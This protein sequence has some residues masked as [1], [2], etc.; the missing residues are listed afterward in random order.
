[1][2]GFRVNAVDWCIPRP[3]SMNAA[4]LETTSEETMQPWVDRHPLLFVLLNISIVYATVSVVISYVGGWASLSKRF[5]FH[6][7]FSGS[8]WRGQSGQ[9]RWIAGYRSYLTVGANEDGLYLATFPFFPLGHPPLLIPWNEVSHTKR[10]MLFFPMVRFELG[11]DTAVPFWVRESLAER[12]RHVAG[13]AWPVG[14][15]E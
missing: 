6:G 7:Q 12:L 13:K 11:R 2:I 10:R 1:M 5:R 8:R 15:N 14:H 4:R 3:A 9:M